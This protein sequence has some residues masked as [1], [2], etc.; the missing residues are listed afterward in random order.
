MDNGNLIN[1][2]HLDRLQKWEDQSKLD[3]KSIKRKFFGC[4]A[5]LHEDFT[6]LTKEQIEELYKEIFGF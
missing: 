3:S 4:Q 5:D 1:S 6:D 2:L